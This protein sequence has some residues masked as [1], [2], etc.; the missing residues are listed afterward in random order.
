MNFEVQSVEFCCE[1]S[2]VCADV[3]FLAAAI[4]VERVVHLYRESEVMKAFSRG[5]EVVVVVNFPA[6]VGF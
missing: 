2:E 6:Y 1:S 5:F 4:V 3:G